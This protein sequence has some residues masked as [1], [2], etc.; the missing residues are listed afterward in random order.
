MLTLETADMR[1]RRLIFSESINGMRITGSQI[2]QNLTN[3]G[4]SVSSVQKVLRDL[5]KDNVVQ[6]KKISGQG[7]GYDYEYWL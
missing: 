5:R 7:S 6:H 4:Y 2:K 1:I 3:A